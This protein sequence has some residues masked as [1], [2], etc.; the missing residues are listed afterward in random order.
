MKNEIFDY[1]YPMI[2]HIHDMSSGFSIKNRSRVKE[3]SQGASIQ[4]LGYSFRCEQSEHPY[5]YLIGK[6]FHKSELKVCKI[7]DR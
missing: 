3:Q 4:I 6:Y 2:L 7:H 1:Q 5:C